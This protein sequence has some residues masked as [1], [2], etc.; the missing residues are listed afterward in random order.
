MRLSYYCRTVKRI[1]L[2]CRHLDEAILKSMHST[3][4]FFSVG[5][6]ESL[7]PQN[8]SLVHLYVSMEINFLGNL[9]SH[10]GIKPGIPE[11]LMA[12][13]NMTLKI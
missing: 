3:D 8:I 12:F 2:L 4:P 13:D 10:I 5:H 6:A 9:S 11:L 7:V 1:Q